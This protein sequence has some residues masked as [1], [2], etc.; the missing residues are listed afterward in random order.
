MAKVTFAG[1]GTEQLGVSMLSAIAKVNGHKTNLAFSAS[2]FHDRFNLEMPWLSPYFDDSREVIKAI[3]KQEPDVLA[4]SPL[5][6][7]YQW[8]L[9]V[10]GKA[11]EL[12]PGIK[13]VFGGFMLPRFRTYFSKS[14]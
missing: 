6:A 13:T 11:K 9:D 1:L 10:A 12:N 2:L 5:T 14:R 4:I 7:T 8:S 3:E